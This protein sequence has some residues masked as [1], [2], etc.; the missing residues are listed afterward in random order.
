MDF[1]KAWKS[2]SQPRKQ[3]KFRYNAPLHIRQKLTKAHLSKELR[4]KYGFRSIQLRKGDTVKIA[5]GDFRKKTG[6][7]ERVDLKKGKVYVS[8]ADSVKKD[9]SK[10]FYPLNPSKLIVT[11]LSG[12]DDRKRKKLIERTAGKEKK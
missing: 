4:S 3:R 7:V 12:M 1:S 2:S 8:G 11:E 10:A 6:K 5:R 9:G